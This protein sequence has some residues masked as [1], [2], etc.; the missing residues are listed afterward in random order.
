[1]WIRNLALAGSASLLLGLAACGGGG[2]GG[3]AGAALT[4]TPSS[5]SVE[6]DPGE[7]FGITLEAQAHFNASGTVYVFVVDSAGLLSSQVNLVDLGNSKYQVTV[8]P[9]SS[10][11]VG[12]HQGEF[13]LHLCPT[14]DCSREYSG[15]PVKLP[16]DF[17]VGTP[18]H[19]TPISALPGVADWETFQRDAAHAGHVPIE[20]DAADFSTRWRWIDPQQ[21]RHLSP[22][23]VAN[24]T[25]FVSS[26]GIY[27][28][29]DARLYALDEHDASVRWRHDFGAVH[30]LNPPAVSGSAVFVATS[31]HA[32][33]AMWSFSAADGT[34]RFRSPFDS[35]GDR[36]RA[37]VVRDGSV[38]TNGGYYGGLLRFDAGTGERIWFRDVNTAAPPAIDSSNAYVTTAGHLGASRLSDGQS[39]YFKSFADGDNSLDCSKAAAPVLTGDGRLLTLS[40]HPVRTAGAVNTLA[41]LD[42][43]SQNVLWSVKGRFTT[44][45]VFAGDVL[46]VGNEATARIEARSLASG[47]LLWSWALPEGQSR[48]VGN[49]VL[50]NNL[51]FLS[52]EHQ[53][54]A[55]DIATRKTVWTYRKP[56]DK[57]ISAQGVLYI[58]TTNPDGVSDRG[59]TAV[60]LR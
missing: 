16:Y 57:A 50:T 56:G 51:L 52:S 13:E 9:S 30:A 41:L 49:L 15:S 33:T 17:S 6:M 59:L 47:A 21:W 29:S 8:Y 22:P 45:P 11:P 19:L 14:P 3:G 26:S 44:D 37:P 39:L 31:G 42:L 53:T 43:A 5:L 36:Y 10:P 4:F 38:Y 25:V 58:S 48:F 2:G 24:G 32:D 35:Q 40:C 12:R 28:G 18:P 54:F 20:V 27:S 60:N 34:Q 46:Y 23:V 1:M 7:V 55:L